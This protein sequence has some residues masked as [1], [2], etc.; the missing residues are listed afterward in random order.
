MAYDSQA[1]EQLAGLSPADKA[2]AQT[3][4]AKMTL[5]QEQR[6]RLLESVKSN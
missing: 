6:A 3:I 1:V 4:I 2:A 5:P